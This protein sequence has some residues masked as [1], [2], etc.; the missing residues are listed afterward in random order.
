MTI[1]DIKVGQPFSELSTYIVED[2][3]NTG[4]KFKHLE[5]DSIVRVDFEY[6]KDCMT[7]ADYF[8]E[9]VK[10]GKKDKYYTQKQVDDLAAIGTTNLPAV[11]AVRLKG[12]ESIFTDIPYKKVFTATFRKKGKELNDKEV[13]AQKD[14]IIAE[15]VAKIQKTKEQKKGVAD[16]AE[17][18]LRKALDTTVETYVPG[19]I[20]ELRGY[21][22]K[23]Y[24]ADGFY[25]V[26]DLDFP[27][28]KA[29]KKGDDTR[30][31]N[32]NTL[33]ELI[34]DGVKYILE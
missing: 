15:A 3:D 27:D 33:E 7:S 2:I 19:D 11:G 6:V 29:G 4:V 22:T 16:V 30:L 13:K 14:K 12:M 28:K 5:S 25:Q 8:E 10:V 17:Q 23:Q 20:R 32:I 34:V 18:E 26:L 21:K 24:S 31:V 9:V 1:Q